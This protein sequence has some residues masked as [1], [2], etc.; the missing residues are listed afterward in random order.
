M[1]KA[2]F[3]V[4][5]LNDLIRYENGMVMPRAYTKIAD[6]LYN[7]P[8]REDDIWIVTYPKTG[9]TWTQEM[10]WMLVNDV[11]KEA[12]NVPQMVRSP[13]LELA[14]LTPLESLKAKDML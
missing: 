12:A 4:S 13:F 11:D 14:C 10:V 8:L 7:F 6:N 1:V 5:D 9:T 2:S 3:P